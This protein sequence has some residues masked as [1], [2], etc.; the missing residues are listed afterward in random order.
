M[1]ELYGWDTTIV[2]ITRRTTRGFYLKPKLSM[3]SMTNIPE[4]EAKFKKYHIEWIMR[5]SGTH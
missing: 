3:V 4:F 2:P 5:S 1:Q